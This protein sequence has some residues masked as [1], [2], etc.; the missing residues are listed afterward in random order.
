[1]SFL[2][3]K[4]RQAV[5]K[6]LR[7]DGQAKPR[8]GPSPLPSCFILIAILNKRRKKTQKQGPEAP[9]QLGLHTAFLSG[10]AASAVSSV[11]FSPGSHHVMVMI[12]ARAQEAA[13]SS[14]TSPCHVALP[15]VPAPA[16]SCPGFGVGGTHGLVPWLAPTRAAGSSHPTLTKN[17]AAEKSPVIK[18]LF[19]WL[20][21]RRVCAT[22]KM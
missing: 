6:N 12:S 5:A 21:T 3:T 8:K 18:F 14:I 19:L 17:V 1:M 13:G 7:H 4:I 11:T 2:I 15:G 22:D 20:K 10:P 16:L 9:T